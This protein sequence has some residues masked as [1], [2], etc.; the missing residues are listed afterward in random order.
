MMEENKDEEEFLCRF[1]YQNI[2][3]RILRSRNS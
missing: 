1:I 3:T 2:I